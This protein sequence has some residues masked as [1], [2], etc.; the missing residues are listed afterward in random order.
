MGFLPE[1]KTREMRNA[2]QKTNI[3][4]SNTQNPGYNNA[5]YQTTE[6]NKFYKLM[7]EK[8]L[9]SISN[10]IEK[11]VR[12]MIQ[13]PHNKF[14]TTR[15]LELTYI[16]K[17]KPDAFDSKNVHDVIFGL[18]EIQ[19]PPVG[20]TTI[21]FITLG[22]AYSKIKKR[23]PKCMA[24][25]L[26]KDVTTI[27]EFC[28][29]PPAQQYIEEVCIHFCEI[30][31]YSESFQRSYNSKALSVVDEKQPFTDIKES[32]INNLRR[33]DTGTL[34]SSID[35]LYI[36]FPV[37]DGI[38][39]FIELSSTIFNDF[40]SYGAEFLNQCK[41]YITNCNCV[42]EFNVNFIDKFFSMDPC[43]FKNEYESI[44]KEVTSQNNGDLLRAIKIL[45]ISI[46][47]F[48]RNFVRN[49]GYRSNQNYTLYNYHQLS[50]L[51]QTIINSS[52]G[53]YAVAIEAFGVFISRTPYN[54]YDSGSGYLLETIS[55]LIAG[56]KERKLELLQTLYDI[57]YPEE[58][59][60][61]F[62][63]SLNIICQLL[64][65]FNEQSELRWSIKLIFKLLFYANK[66]KESTNDEAIVL[67]RNYTK[68]NQELK[69][70]YDRKDMVV[71]S[72]SLL[73]IFA[74]TTA[75]PTCGLK[76]IDIL[77]NDEKELLFQY[78]I[79]S[80][81]NSSI[82]EDFTFSTDDILKKVKDC[83]DK[84][85]TLGEFLS[86]F[87]HKKCFNASLVIRH[88]DW[89]P[90]LITHLSY[91]P[92][93]FE[94]WYPSFSYYGEDLGD[95]ESISKIF[96]YKLYDYLRKL[97]KIPEC[98]QNL[99]PQIKT[100]EHFLRA[101]R[102][103]DFSK[104]SELMYK[105]ARKMNVKDRAF[106]L[107]CFQTMRIVKGS[108]DFNFPK[109]DELLQVFE[110]A[111]LT[112]KDIVIASI[113]GQ[114]VFSHK[115]HSEVDRSRPILSRILRGTSPMLRQSIK[116]SQIPTC[117]FKEYNFTPAS[118]SSI[119]SYRIEN[120]RRKK[121]VDF[122]DIETRNIDMF[123][124][125]QPN[126]LRQSS[127]DSIEI[128]KINEKIYH[129]LCSLELIETRN[130][131]RYF[132]L[133]QLKILVCEHSVAFDIFLDPVAPLVKIYFNPNASNIPEDKWFFLHCIL[134][135]C[136]A[137]MK[138]DSKGFINSRIFTEELRPV[139]D[140][141]K[142]FSG[143][144]NHPFIEKLRKTILG[145]TSINFLDRDIS[146]SDVLSNKQ[147]VDP[148]LCSITSNLPHKNDSLLMELA[149]MNNH[150]DF[151]GSEVF[152]PL[153]LSCS[154][155]AIAIFLSHLP[156]NKRAQVRST[157]TEIICSQFDFS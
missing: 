88:Q 127:D 67:D 113:L 44:K 30:D 149:L 154:E 71:K 109:T 139:L 6:V 148:F 3:S 143:I 98:D 73:I 33:I 24:Y 25:L 122:G 75:S 131:A 51:V 38:E 69:S 103:I 132:P 19:R 120:N 84:K 11:S 12:Y 114:Y 86:E 68:M 157:L 108:D 49:K 105:L 64:E 56:N 36:F 59:T 101:K 61:G 8:S 130:K 78:L 152:I 85:I 2:P 123:S 1:K 141:E 46:D 20:I 80:M 35:F 151:I 57:L 70:I 28:F 48:C 23:F 37:K 42:D 104:K 58:Y 74:I 134:C 99:F 5:R 110:E 34:N 128:S 121:K 102:K 95:I 87:A 156:Q 31:R 21:L 135:V 91:E 15:Y 39:K 119:K 145:D 124:Y 60:M 142:N 32:V 76:L 100:F 72:I 89:T 13:Q 94:E 107:A 29:F 17:K 116:L 136:L 138:T 55:N 93:E 133:S 62:P 147:A 43:G 14:Q 40:N 90:Y 92:S 41:R 144:K 63:L 9:E 52:M 126:M 146:I 53:D 79:R 22:C 153:I 18:K 155:D 83:R 137:K 26:Y 96:F 117:D 106:R 81:S 115:E 125:R 27:K 4:N 54:M 77:D 10:S 50:I 97:P 16:A 82:S 150:D 112:E 7:N 111:L 45:G 47:E 129:L 65:F 140:N 66:A 118:S